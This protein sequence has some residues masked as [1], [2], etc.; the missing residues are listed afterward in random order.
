M[1]NFDYFDALK[2]SLEQAV[3]YTKGD[4]SRCRTVV[5]ETPIPAYKADDVART[6]KELKLSQRGLATALGVSPRTVEHR[7]VLHN[8]CSI[9]LNVITRWWSA[10]W[11]A[12]IEFL[13]TGYDIALTAISCTLKV[14]Q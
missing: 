1:E 8:G 3:D 9:C 2:E 5:R 4:K 10:W 11:L 6:R 14:T 12:E 13:S 7:L